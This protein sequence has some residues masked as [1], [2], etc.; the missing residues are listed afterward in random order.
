VGLEIST[1]T[2][3]SVRLVIEGKEGVE[4]LPE[5]RDD[6]EWIQWVCG[7]SDHVE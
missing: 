4:D 7:I 1:I 5:L 2:R 3:I 6:R